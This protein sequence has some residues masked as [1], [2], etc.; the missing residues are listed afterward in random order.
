M[1]SVGHWGPGLRKGNLTMNTI[2]RRV[3]AAALAATLAA[4]AAVAATTSASA[5]PYCGITW[6]ST[7]KATS[8]SLLWT[9][10]VTSARAGQ[11]ACFDRVVF[12]LAPGRGTLGYRVR[13]VSAVTSPG[14]GLPVAVTGGARI[15]VTV[16][17]PSTLGRST[18]TFTGWRTFR[19]LKG[20]G[21]FEG[22]TDYGLGVR[23]RLPMRAFV[24]ADADGGRRLVV[25][26]A[27]AW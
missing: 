20:I 27:H 2:S 9:G 17:A 13:Y 11:H 24:L 26:V 22:Y 21:S 3:A 23:A 1:W 7:T 6:G 25:D 14:S 16:D 5:A 4:P 8:P 18:T 15:Q 10:R 19:Q 12:D